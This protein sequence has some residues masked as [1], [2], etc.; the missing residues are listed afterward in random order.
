MAV[1]DAGFS[2]DEEICKGICEKYKRF[3]SDTE[4]AELLLSIQSNPNPVKLWKELNEMLEEHLN[5]TDFFVV[6]SPQVVPLRCYVDRMFSK[7][8]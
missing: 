8:F 2:F 4:Q 6:D 1:T 7:T 5:I 3:I